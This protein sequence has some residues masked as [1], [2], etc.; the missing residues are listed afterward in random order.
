ME[1]DTIR[2][3]LNYDNLTGGL[4]WNPISET[5]YLSKTWNK[6][7]AG[8]EAGTI[9]GDGYRY[10]SVA[11]KRYA[12]HRVAWLLTYGEWPKDQI[13][14][15]NHIRLDNAILNLRVVDRATNSKNRTKQANNTSGINGVYFKK[16]ISRWCAYI[17]IETK[18]KH[19]GYFKTKDE[20]V[21][22]RLAANKF[23]GFHE[24][25][26]DATKELTF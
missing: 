5:D 22:A 26:G 18:M 24:N 14:H 19:L 25:H 13:D 20:A 16:S 8:Q 21:A 3:R 4:F 23:Y 1:R 6:R 11:D 15:I 9:M 10:I 17:K 7:F 2:K 12:A